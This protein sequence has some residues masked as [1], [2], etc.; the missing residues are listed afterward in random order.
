MELK[1]VVFML[2]RISIVLTIK[3]EKNARL[4]KIRGKVWIMCWPLP[5]RRVGR[6]I[7]LK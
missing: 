5:Q 4:L 6:N 7:K 1:L 3:L 2:V